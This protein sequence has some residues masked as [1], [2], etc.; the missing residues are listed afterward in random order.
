VVEVL[1]AADIDGVP[2]LVEV[3]SAPGTEQTASPVRP[4][5]RI[6]EMFVHAESVISKI[7]ESAVRVGR[8]IARQAQSPNKVEVQ[9]GLA[10]TAQGQIV[11]AKAT[12]EASLS[13]KVTYDAVSSVQ[14]TAAP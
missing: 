11:I 2:V 7:A 3:M 14:E 6:H 13:V 8:Q 5:E 10:F 9:F 4:A 12:V 1:V